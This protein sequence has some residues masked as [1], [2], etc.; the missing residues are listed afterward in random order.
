MD[1]HPVLFDDYTGRGYIGF[2]GRLWEVKSPDVTQNMTR[3]G[4]MLGKEPSVRLLSLRP[5]DEQALREEGRLR[6]LGTMQGDVT[7]REAAQLVLCEQMNRAVQKEYMA[8]PSWTRCSGGYGP[9]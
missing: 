1:E 8:F 9:V 4:G 2:K 5:R 3:P 7:V 6:L